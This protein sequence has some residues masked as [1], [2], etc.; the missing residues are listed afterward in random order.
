MRV[1][2][3]GVLK[4]MQ[5][6]ERLSACA[7]KGLTELRS[8][9]RSVEVRAREQEISSALLLSES[10]N[11]SDLL[12]DARLLAAWVLRVDDVLHCDRVLCAVDLALV[13]EA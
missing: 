13:S 8:R 4:L 2:E 7:V 5:I 6:A 1:R 9:G 10:H 3:E 11:A 12:N